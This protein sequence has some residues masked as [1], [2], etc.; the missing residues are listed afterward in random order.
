MNAYFPLR[1]L[2]FVKGQNPQL[3]KNN[4]NNNIITYKNKNDIRCYF[5]NVGGGNR[6]VGGLDSEKFCFE[7]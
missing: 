6:I 4:N 7:T 5:L 3:P 2:A 1:D